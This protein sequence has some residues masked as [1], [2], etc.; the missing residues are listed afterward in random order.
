MQLVSNSLTSA[1][2][3]LRACSSYH[4]LVLVSRAVSISPQALIYSF[5]NRLILCSK[6]KQKELWTAF[7]HSMKINSQAVHTTLWKSWRFTFVQK[8]PNSTNNRSWLWAATV[9]QK[10]TVGFVGM[11]HQ[12]CIFCPFLY[13]RKIKNLQR[14]FRTTDPRGNPGKRRTEWLPG[15]PGDTTIQVQDYAPYDCIIALT[16]LSFVPA[17][18]IAAMKQGSH[19]THKNSYICDLIVSMLS[20]G[21]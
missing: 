21:L 2:L 10:K 15:N 19:A 1:S 20:F 9:S 13:L 14:N 5:R 8:C 18:F 11:S 16:H 12:A 3:V 6:N 17:H 7:A 4:E